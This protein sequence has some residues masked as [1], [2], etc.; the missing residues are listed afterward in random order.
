[1]KIE[2]S[3]VVRFNNELIT[4]CEKYRE[5]MIKSYCTDSYYDYMRGWFQNASYTELLKNALTYILNGQN[6]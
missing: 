1:M 2:K 4:L 5:H 3:K 6:M